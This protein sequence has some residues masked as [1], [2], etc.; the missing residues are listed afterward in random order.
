MGGFGAWFALGPG[1]RSQSAAPTGQHSRLRHTPQLHAILALG[2]TRW[3]A[4]VR[5]SSLRSLAAGTW[6]CPQQPRQDVRVGAPKFDLLHRRKVLAE[7]EAGPRARGGARSRAHARVPSPA[8]PPGPR[9]GGARA[10]PRRGRT[11]SPVAVSPTVTPRYASA[12][13]SGAAGASA[14]D[15][16]A[17]SAL[18]GGSVDTLTS[19]SSGAT[20]RPTLRGRP[21]VAGAS[22]SRSAGGSAGARSA[23]ALEA[24]G[25]GASGVA[26][27]FATKARR[28]RAHRRRAGARARAAARPSS[29]RRP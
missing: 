7:A 18:A 19:S 6:D 15:S 3:R 25:P 13:L 12:G 22:A 23:W 2:P 20:A 28:S 29:R 8:R 24:D 16:P 17:G 10:G 27:A 14:G 21:S 11:A 26:S 4:D 5:C 9:R 1:G